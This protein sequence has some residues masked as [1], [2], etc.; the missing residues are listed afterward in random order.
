MFFLPV[1]LEANPFN[2]VLFPALL[3]AD[4]FDLVFKHLGSGS[5]IPYLQRLMKI[6]ITSNV[7]RNL[8][9]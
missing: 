8:G 5:Y 1:F 6:T 9:F 2:L 4:P 7:F 3:E